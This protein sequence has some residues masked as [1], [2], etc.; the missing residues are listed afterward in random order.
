MH[1][2]RNGKKEFHRKT[3]NLLILSIRLLLPFDI[4]Q[5]RQKGIECFQY[6]GDLCKLFLALNSYQNLCTTERKLVVQRENDRSSKVRYTIVYVFQ[7]GTVLNRLTIQENAETVCVVT[8]CWIAI[9]LWTTTTRT[10]TSDNHE[11]V[12]I[13]LRENACLIL[14]ALSNLSTVYVY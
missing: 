14:P 3:L 9:T 6:L 12:R 4:V 7:L 5:V 2:I 13:P 11:C 10:S 1:L 8:F